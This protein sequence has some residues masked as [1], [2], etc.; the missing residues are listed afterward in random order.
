[1]KK[2]IKRLVLVSVALTLST[3]LFAA[4]PKLTPELKEKLQAHVGILEEWVKEP[5]IINAV[6]AQN[7]QGLTMDQIKERDT[8]WIATRKSKKA[9]DAFMQQLYNHE[10]GK[11]IRQKNK[12]SKGSYPEAFLCDNQGANVAVSKYTSDYWQGDEGKWQKSFNNGQGQV[13]FGDPEYDKSSKAMQVQVSVPVN[14][15]GSTIGVLVVGVKFSSLKK[16]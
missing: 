11:W 13:F 6:K 4:G 14:D 10:V 9:P 2:L 1:M 3:S 12:E 16:K 15:G 8:K 7:G 5:A